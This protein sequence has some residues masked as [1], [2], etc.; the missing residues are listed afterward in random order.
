MT[1]VHDVNVTS[2]ALVMT[3]DRGSKAASEVLSPAQTGLRLHGFS[4]VAPGALADNHG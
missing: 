2:T 4:G 1:A 3:A